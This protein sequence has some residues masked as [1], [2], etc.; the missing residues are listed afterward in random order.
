MKPII[1]VAAGL[2]L[3]D[4]KYL[5]SQRKANG[6]LPFFWEF[7]GG[8]K[9]LG[10]TLEVCLKRELWEELGIQVAVNFLVMQHSYAYVDRIVELYFYRC[11]IREGIPY[12]KDCH[13]LKWIAPFQMQEKF[14]PPADALLIR[15]LQKL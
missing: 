9:E 14:F 13:D 4:G 5:I 10:E 8:K 3:K 1:Q 11:M 15:R 12:K 7:P 2:I 6:H